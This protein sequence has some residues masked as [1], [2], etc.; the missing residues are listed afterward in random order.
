M[1]IAF[2][3]YYPGTAVNH[4][5]QKNSPDNSDPLFVNQQL[6][7]L[8]FPTEYEAIVREKLAPI[9]RDFDAAL[10]EL[11]AGFTRINTLAGKYFQEQVA[12]ESLAYDTNKLI[13]DECEGFTSNFQG[14]NITSLTLTVLHESALNEIKER[15]L[16]AL[17]PLI[18]NLT[19]KEEYYLAS[20]DLSS[21]ISR[22]ARQ[23]RRTIDSDEKRRSILTDKLEKLCESEK[24]DENHPSAEPPADSKQNFASKESQLHQSIEDILESNEKRQ[25][26][27]VTLEKSLEEATAWES[28]NRE[29]LR[30]ALTAA[31]EETARIID[32]L[33]RAISVNTVR[34]VFI[35]RQVKSELPAVVKSKLDNTSGGLEKN[36]KE[37]LRLWVKCMDT[38]AKRDVHCVEIRKVLKFDISMADFRKAAAEI[39]APGSTERSALHK[40]IRAAYHSS[41]H[42]PP[43]TSHAE[44][45]LTD[46]YMEQFGLTP[47]QSLHYVRVF[48]RAALDPALEILR[49]RRAGARKLDGTSLNFMCH[50]MLA[51][52]YLSCDG[53]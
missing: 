15:S 20:L 27:A 53:D 4:M 18:K 39:L 38:V 10:R 45:R 31:S 14:K 49:T 24:E 33:H 50:L 43:L 12:S 7:G 29:D 25:D 48:S 42:I 52:H 34:L 16:P 21:Q 44:P 23:L 37:L 41:K 22:E 13:T 47:E 36:A 30:A 51:H 17:E 26:R 46:I 8:Q 28:K 6:S 40:K 9:K 1:R 19:Q 32:N 35:H 2:A 11:Q 5:E 3:L